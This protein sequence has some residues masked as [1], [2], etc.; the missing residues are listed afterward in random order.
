MSVSSTE[1][2]H[3]LD[4]ILYDRPAGR[5]IIDYAIETIK[6][7]REQGQ[8]NQKFFDGQ[9]SDWENSEK[10]YLER[11]RELKASIEN[12]QESASKNGAFRVTWDETNAQWRASKG[13]EELSLKVKAWDALVAWQTAERKP[14]AT[15]D[16][17]FPLMLAYEKA[18]KAAGW[19]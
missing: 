10:Q 16:E 4:A 5:N 8:D 19:Q 17:V 13:Y 9:Y 6:E 1:N 15:E 2:L 7:L 18:A 3:I 14:G 12:L 11:I